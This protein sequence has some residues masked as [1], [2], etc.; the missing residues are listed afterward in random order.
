MSEREEGDVGKERRGERSIK[1]E[2]TRGSWEWKRRDHVVV[3]T[4]WELAKWS[5]Q[6]PEYH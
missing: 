2:R 1:R 3:K 5:V 6:T 4:V